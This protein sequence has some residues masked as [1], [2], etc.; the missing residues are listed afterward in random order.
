MRLSRAFSVPLKAFFIFVL[1][2]AGTRGKNRLILY[3][4]Q[5][6]YPGVA[7]GEAKQIESMPGK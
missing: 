3:K 1:Y 5:E 2:K 6:P 4:S 7:E